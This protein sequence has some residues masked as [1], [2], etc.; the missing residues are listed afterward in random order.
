MQ[1]FSLP[2]VTCTASPKDIVYMVVNNLQCA[3]GRDHLLQTG[4]YQA[5]IYHILPHTPTTGHQYPF[6]HS[7]LHPLLAGICW[8][9]IGGSRD[10]AVLLL[11]FHPVV[12][13]EIPH[14]VSLPTPLS[15][16]VYSCIGNLFCDSSLSGLPSHYF[17]L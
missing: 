10:R 6:M 11:C 13:A 3:R 17:L 5:S 14:P 2:Q 12:W 9:S 8:A 7:T 15:P 1:K 16:S 4:L